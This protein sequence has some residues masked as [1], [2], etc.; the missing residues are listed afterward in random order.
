MKM[1]NII[2][3]I[4]LSYIGLPTATF[5]VDGAPQQAWL[6]RIARE[7]NDTK[8][9][10]GIN[11]V[12]QTIAEP[13]F[14]ALPEIL[15]DAQVALIDLCQVITKAYILVVLVSDEQFK[16]INP[17]LSQYQLLIDTRG[18]WSNTK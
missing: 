15:S 8:S 6:I 13:N 18:I 5:I 10:W 7:V 9:N 11:K 17:K 3:I 4:G 16:C 2:S 12:A 1:F 14:Q